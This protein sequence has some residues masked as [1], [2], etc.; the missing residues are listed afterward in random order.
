MKKL[1]TPYVLNYIIG[2]VI[3]GVHFRGPYGPVDSGRRSGGRT[4][5]C[6]HKGTK[7]RENVTMGTGVKGLDGDTETRAKWVERDMRAGVNEWKETEAGVK[8][9]NRA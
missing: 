2:L 4:Q 7:A 5:G 8:G 3:F 1:L 6:C 9:D